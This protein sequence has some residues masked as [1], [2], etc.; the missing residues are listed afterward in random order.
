MATLGPNA[1]ST[2]IAPEYINYA[3]STDLGDGRRLIEA[4][5]LIYDDSQWI[6]TQWLEFYEEPLILG[7]TTSSDTGYEFSDYE[8]LSLS[9]TLPPEAAEPLF[10]EDKRSDAY[11]SIITQPIQRPTPVFVCYPYRP[12]GGTPVFTNSLVTYTLTFS[13]LSTI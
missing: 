9:F 11:I 5:M 6:Q 4:S 12:G 2:Q 8:G 7:F 13:L 3:F 10:V 1:S